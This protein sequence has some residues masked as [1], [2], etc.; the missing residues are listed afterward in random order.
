MR[1]A[2]TASCESPVVASTV[3]ERSALSARLADYLIL[4]KPRIA[5]LALLTVSAG[6][7]LGSAD[8]WYGW[9]LAHALL[10]IALVAAGS[11]AL[12]QYLERES[13]A[14]MRRTAGRPLPSGRLSPAEVLLFGLTTG[15]AG[16]LYL[17]V[18]VNLT[19]SALAAA[20]MVLY[21]GIY[22]PLKRYSAFATAVG[23]VP[24]ALPPVLGWTASGAALDAGAFSLFAILFLWQFP[25]FLAI[26]WI[27]RDE[28]ARA[29]L[30]MLP[31]GGR[32]PKVVGVLAVGYALVL[33]PLSLYPAHCGLAG[34][35]Y[36]AVAL[37]LSLAYLTAAVRFALDETALT[38]RRL[39][40]S[41][42]I[43][44]PVLLVTLVWD[45]FRLLT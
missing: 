29:G 16:M 20:T 24:G 22:T 15:L 7:A 12:N 25:H 40:W 6:Y 18:C 26:G 4:T 28:Y 21:A 36:L 9:P 19:T 43:Y 41:S 32:A 34:S 23:A 1:T 44:L 5:L 30:R 2:A 13:D 11:S 35:G 37:I 27:Y 42:L 39:L 3:N 33:V 31:G 45:H 17:A 8:Q 14:R 10:G 38:A